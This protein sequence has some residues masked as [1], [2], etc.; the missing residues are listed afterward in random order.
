MMEIYILSLSLELKEHLLGAGKLQNHVS[1]NTR[2][3]LSFISSHQS[4]L[5]RLV[6]LQQY[7]SAKYSQR[8]ASIF[9][10]L[11]AIHQ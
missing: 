1:L 4:Y 10:V 6:Y 5:R 7:M 11:D 9:P 8:K 2:T 3:A